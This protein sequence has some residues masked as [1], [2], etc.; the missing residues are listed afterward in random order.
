MGTTGGAPH[1]RLTG[2]PRADVAPPGV[3]VLA[4]HPWGRENL[5][6]AITEG[7]FR[8]YPAN[9]IGEALSLWQGQ[10]A[11]V[12]VIDCEDWPGA[13]SI[14]AA[15]HQVTRLRLVLVNAAQSSAYRI[16]GFEIG[17]DRILSA[18]LCRR[19]LVALLRALVRRLGLRGDL[20]RTI[21]V[22]GWRIWSERHELLSPEGASV[23]LTHGEF[24]L[25]W[26]LATHAGRYL[27]RASLLEILQLG[28]PA[29]DSRKIDLMVWRIRRKLEP[30]QGG[31]GLIESRRGVGYRLRGA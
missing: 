14:C 26:A 27:G 31:G 25:V 28:S 6:R 30:Y 24:K 22:R 15:L 20:A 21:A 12:A 5:A 9:S 19:E 10:D 8:A 11:G 1:T 4:C 7:G 18:P 16:H 17:A 13:L 3:V 23:A 2:S 29:P